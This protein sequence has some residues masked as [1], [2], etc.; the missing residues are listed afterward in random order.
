MKIGIVG[1][2]RIGGNAASLWAK[3]R[4][5]VMLSYSR[6]PEN[7]E[8]R[9]SAIGALASVGSVREAAEF[10]DVV[11]FSVPWGRIDEVLEEI[12]SDAL[13]GKVVIDTT[14]QF[15]A[16]GLEEVA[17]GKTAAQVNAER[18]SGASYVKAFN[19]LTAGFQGAAAGRSGDERVAMFLC[20]DDDEAKQT[21][22]KL[23]REIGFAPVDVGGTADAAVMEP[24][25]REGAVY[26]EEL[27]KQEAREFLEGRDN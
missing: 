24:P 10:G 3:A 16:D 14:N 20:G 23:I 17:D 11:L 21:A 1:A 6:E 13:E 12:G 27:S 19:T 9:A 4:H 15:G 26:G 7:L 22:K 8:Q 2:G 25:R 18:L 5:E